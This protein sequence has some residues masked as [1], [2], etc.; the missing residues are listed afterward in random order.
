MKIRANGI[1]IEVEDSATGADPMHAQRPVVLLIMG[2]GLQLVAW[3]D[4]LV[5]GLLNAGYR[6]VRFDNRDAGLSTHLSHLGAPN[7][8]WAALQYKLGLTPRAPYTLVDMA[9]DA[10][11]VLDALGVA[12]AHL[13]GMSM[14]GMIAQRVAVAAPQRVLSLTSIMSSSGARGLPGPQPEVLKAM[15]KRPAHGLDATADQ[16]VAL[17]RL[18]GSPVDPIPPEML[19]A[20]VLR[21]ITR[22]LD[23]V[24]V[25]RQMVAVGSDTARADLLPRIAAPTLVVHGKADRLLPFANGEDTAR[26]IPGAKFLG[27]EGMG[28]D[29]PDAHVATL[30][31]TLVPHLQAATPS[32]SPLSTPQPS[33]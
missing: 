20:Q 29:L 8:L 22:N 21:S 30:L 5:N 13:V 7:M 6:V 15:L 18:I 2:L 27:I 33:P 19:R 12:Q 16:F 26:R 32:P 28:H 31:Q 4:S 17:F 3:P 10:L 24:G 14:G 11:G 25:T 9:K 1:D 23:P